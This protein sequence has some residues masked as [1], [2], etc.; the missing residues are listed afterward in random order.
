M[1]MPMLAADAMEMPEMPRLRLAD[2]APADA[3]S[4]DRS[5]TD[6][7]PSARRVGGRLIVDDGATLP[8]ACVVCGDTV[9]RVELTTPRGRVRFTVCREHLILSVARL[10]C[11]LIVGAVAIYLALARGGSRST[12]ILTG[13][14]LLMASAA[15]IA[16]AMPIWTWRDKLGRRRVLRACR[17]V[18]EDV[19]TASR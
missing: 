18:R 15:L 14:A 19:P 17:A 1:S 4:V 2:D 7:A 13:V 16:T 8:A 12:S 11:G 6:A 10:A 9:G 5:A 3:M